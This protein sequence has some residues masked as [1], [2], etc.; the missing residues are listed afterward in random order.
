[1]TGLDDRKKGHEQKF[2]RD[3]E[4]DFKIKSRRNRLFGEWAAAKLGLAGDAVAAYAKEVVAADFEKPGDE[5]V[6]GKVAGDLA[7]KGVQVNDAQLRDEFQRLG[8]V[9]RKQIL[10]E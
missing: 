9:A 3:Q 7:A 10:G 8:V 6:I 1:M 2:A 4:W 5:D